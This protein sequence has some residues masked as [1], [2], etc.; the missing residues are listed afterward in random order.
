MQSKKGSSG[1]TLIELLVVIAIIG[2]LTSVVLASLNSA[3]SK[4]GDAGV[5]DNLSSVRTQAE[6]YYNDNSNYGTAYT[7]GACSA[8]AAGTMFFDN[9]SIKAAIEKAVADGGGDAKCASTATTWA[10]S[11]KLKS[12]TTYWCIDSAGS[13]TTTP[14]GTVTGGVCLAS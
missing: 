3:R 5:K 2:I 8:A 14:N 7:A 6:L 11:A 1:F 9:A 10:V 13:A 4:G 12:A